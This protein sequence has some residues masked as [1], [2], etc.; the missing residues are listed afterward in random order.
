MMTGLGVD[1]AQQLKDIL[2]NGTYVTANRCQNQDIFFAL[3]E[4]EEALLVW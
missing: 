3:G 2:P 1:N 4:A